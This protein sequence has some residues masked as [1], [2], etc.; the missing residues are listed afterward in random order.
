M[1]LCEDDKSKDFQSDSTPINLSLCFHKKK[2]NNELLRT[3]ATL[4]ELLQ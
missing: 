3:D 1:Q 2:V 4:L